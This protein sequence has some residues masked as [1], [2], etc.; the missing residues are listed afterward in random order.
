MS[1]EMVA[2]AFEPFFS[3]KFIGR[4]LGLPAVR[5]IVK[6]HAG[7]L[8]LGSQPGRGTVVE[9]AFPIAPANEFDGPN[10]FTQRT[11]N[12]TVSSTEKPQSIVTQMVLVVDDE[13][14]IRE[15]VAMVLADSG[16][17]VVV[18]AD[19]AE[20]VQLF[21]AQADRFALAVID[22]MM[23]G[24][25]GRDLLQVLRERRP[26]LPVVVVSGFSDWDLIAEFRPSGPITQ[27]TKPFRIEQLLTAIAAVVEPVG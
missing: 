13:P 20:A 17:T 22:L 26:R 21:E 16:R 10:R 15:L 14:N 23:P 19:G 11:K 3:T 24:M 9:V 8:H 4:G 12:P 5:G 18:A 1:A 7:G 2:R 25:N 27:L 6:R